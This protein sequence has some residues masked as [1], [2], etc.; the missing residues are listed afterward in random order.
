MIGYL[1][2]QAARSVGSIETLRPRLPSIFE[3][4]GD[5]GSPEIIA[6]TTRPDILHSAHSAK[7]VLERAIK[8]NGYATS[9]R[10]VSDPDGREND[11]TAARGDNHLESV[12]A[13]RSPL[14]LNVES[15]GH[16][17]SPTISSNEGRSK[18]STTARTDAP[19]GREPVAAQDPYD[20]LSSHPRFDIKSIEH[21]GSPT[22]SGDEA[23]RDV[24]VHFRQRAI[25]AAEVHVRKRIAIESMGII[26]G[27]PTVE[28]RPSIRVSIG[29]IDVRAVAEKDPPRPAR[30][31][32]KRPKLSL[33]EYLRKDKDGRA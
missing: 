29:R 19:Q 18:D 3:P 28:T 31:Q 11:S 21:P 16:R 7:S 27:R 9:E 24:G 22:I 1:S 12:I 17:T 13:V 26:E 10:L 2:L 15:I 32:P 5:D 30:E 14:R 6:E 25:P 33:E 8:A 23:A 20:V 4:A